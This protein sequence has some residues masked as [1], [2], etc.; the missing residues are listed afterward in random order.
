MKL[1]K[2]QKQQ[3]MKKINTEPAWITEMNEKRKTWYSEEAI[4]AR[5]QKQRL[6]EKIRKQQLIEG[7]ELLK[8]IQLVTKYVFPAPKTTTTTHHEER[9]NNN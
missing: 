3:A 6:E 5:K 1:T 8:M 4:A 2:Q 9:L 7:E